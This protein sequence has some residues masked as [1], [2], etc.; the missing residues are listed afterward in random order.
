M[1]L[2]E[3]LATFAI[4]GRILGVGH[5]STRMDLDRLGQDY[6]E[7]VSSRRTW[8]MRDFGVFEVVFSLV[9]AWAW[10]RTTVQAHRLA[11]GERTMP[12]CLQRVRRPIPREVALSDLQ[13]NIDSR[14]K[15]LHLVSEDPDYQRYALDNES[16]PTIT[17]VNDPNAQSAPRRGSIWSISCVA[18]LRGIDSSGL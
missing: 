6:A 13:T 4:S 10:E 18:G 17:V 9:P 14:G 7:T 5:R 2:V 15:S 8:L 16:I 12:D 3:L 11:L 1:T